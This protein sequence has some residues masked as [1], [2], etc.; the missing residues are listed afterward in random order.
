MSEKMLTR[1][2]STESLTASPSAV[3]FVQ[4]SGIGEAGLFGERETQSLVRVASDNAALFLYSV[5]DISTGADQGREIVGGIVRGTVG[6]ILAEL[7]MSKVRQLT[8]CAVGSSASQMAV[9]LF[10]A[11]PMLV[12][13]LLLNGFVAKQPLSGFAAAIDW[14]DMKLPLGLP[15]LP[16]R[17]GEDWRSLLHAVTCPV[18]LFAV[19]GM[20]EQ[21]S[22]ELS[23]ARQR[24][25][26]ARVVKV[27]DLSDAELGALFAEVLAAP[28]KQP[29][30]KKVAA[31]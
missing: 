30:R 19:A 6:G 9:E 2:N 16:R 17:E 12:R 22:K 29:Q 24:I 13:R 1:L 25:P 31:G 11:A 3:L 27:G 7:E 8:V 18:F 20:T 15:L 5:S 10:L 26:S 28:W 21:A 14:L 4:S 23:F